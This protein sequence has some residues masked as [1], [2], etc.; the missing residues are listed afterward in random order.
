MTIDDILFDEMK[1]AVKRLRSRA[2]HFSD[3]PTGEVSRKS[4]LVTEYCDEIS[5]CIATIEKNLD[6]I[7]GIDS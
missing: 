7:D 5:D 2:E 6:H 3:H 4:H 1:E